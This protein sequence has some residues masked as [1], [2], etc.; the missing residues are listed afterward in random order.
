MSFPNQSDPMLYQALACGRPWVLGVSN[1]VVD[2]C[3]LGVMDSLLQASV[4]ALEP[5]RYST[6]AFQGE[7]GPSPI[8]GAPGTFTA[9]NIDGNNIIFSQN[10]ELDLFTTGIGEPAPGEWWLN[11]ISDTDLLRSGAP[12]NRGFM[13][14]STGMTA[15]SHHPFQQ[16]GDGL[17]TATNPKLYSAWLVN[18]PNGP[19][20]STTIQSMILNYAGVQVQFA[21]EGQTYRL[22]TV[23]QYPQF[24]G[25]RGSGDISNGVTYAPG[26]YLPF[27]TGIAFG[28]RDDLKQMTATVTLGQEV[29]IQNNAVVKTVAGS[30]AATS[31]TINAANNGT[32]YA[33]LRLLFIGYIICVPFE[34]YCGIPQLTPD[35]VIALRAR[36][37]VGPLGNN[38]LSPPG[39]TNQPPGAPWGGP[40][41]S[42]PP[43]GSPVPPYSPPVGG[44]PL[45]PG[46]PVG[47][48]VPIYSPPGGLKGGPVPPGS[49]TGSPV[50][51]A[52]PGGG[53]G[54][55]PVGGGL[56][57]SPVPNY[58]RPLTGGPVPSAPPGGGGGGGGMNKL[59]TT[60]V[61][62]IQIPHPTQAT[63]V[64][65]LRPLQPNNSVPSSPPAVTGPSSLNIFPPSTTP[66][67]S[68]MNMVA[69]MAPPSY[70][71]LSP[72]NT[73]ASSLAP[74]PVTNTGTPVGS[75]PLTGTPVPVKPPCPTPP[76][77]KSAADQAAWMAANPGCPVSQTP[78]APTPF[79]PMA[80][81][82]R[83]T[84]PVGIKPQGPG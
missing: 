60:P 83:P 34:N 75:Q 56:S 21:D 80:S 25:P 6:G 66:I 3:G 72:V 78:A 57:G 7:L 51:V 10:Q 74:K 58:K 53:F 64:V 35:E 70:V 26:T 61:T 84:G 54:K 67:N 73:P 18:A 47:S 48:P 63:L 33:P 15:E 12:I 40:V 45:F 22:G 59:V 24:G 31:K 68:P 4:N 76:T 65:P 55:P 44:I 52:P 20:Y 50:P 79:R 71:G 69:P 32:V 46:N 77:F 49:L 16:S 37:G 36:M 17:N 5:F 42:A 30:A 29:V 13:Y 9:V 62:P 19:G 81:Y 14:L 27:T 41:P 39:S 2:Y 23:G 82:T 1:Q 28:S 38:P 11:T 8:S 43:Q